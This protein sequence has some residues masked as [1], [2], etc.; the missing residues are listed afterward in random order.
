VTYQQIDLLGQRRVLFEQLVHP[1]ADLQNRFGVQVRLFELL[2]GGF[3]GDFLPDHDDRQQYQ[4]EEG[5]RDPR[6]KGA[7]ARINGLR[8]AD[9]RQ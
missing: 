8:E 4:L 1:V 3:G 5:L 2:V 7:R 6:D 9:K